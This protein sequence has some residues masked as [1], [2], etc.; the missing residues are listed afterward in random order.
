MLINILLFFPEFHRGRTELSPGDGQRGLA[1]H[2]LAPSPSATRAAVAA[3]IRAS[4]SAITLRRGRPGGIAG[5]N[6]RMM[7][8]GL[9]GKLRRPQNSPEVTATGT[10]GTPS[11]V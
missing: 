11:W 8:P 9:L 3:S 7:R 2:R 5:R 10:S 4:S 6:S 1:A